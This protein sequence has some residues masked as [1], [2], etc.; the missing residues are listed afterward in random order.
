MQNIY[1][2]LC[3][4]LPKSGTDLEP[5]CKTLEK[6]EHR[7]IISN[8]LFSLTEML[9]QINYTLWVERKTKDIR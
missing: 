9:L 1:F 5:P 6:P 7:E 3:N 2:L 4:V 8:D